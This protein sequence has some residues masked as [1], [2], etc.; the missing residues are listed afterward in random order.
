MTAVWPVVSMGKG[1]RLR[2]GGKKKGANLQ[3]DDFQF[4]LKNTSF[5]LKDIEDFHEVGIF[6]SL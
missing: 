2:L 5:D 4:L 6:T 1:K 3:N